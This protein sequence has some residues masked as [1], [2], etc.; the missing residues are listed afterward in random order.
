[1]DDIEQLLKQIPYRRQIAASHPEPMR[2]VC[3]AVVK[4]EE[5]RL[6]TM[7]EPREAAQA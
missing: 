7:Q 6:R 2:T 1:L 5:R 4:D 3:L